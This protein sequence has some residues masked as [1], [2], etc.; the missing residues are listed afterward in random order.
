MQ[1]IDAAVVFLLETMK[2]EHSD[3]NIVSQ[4][5]R[6]IENIQADDPTGPVNEA[7]AGIRELT[8][9]GAAEAQPVEAT[10]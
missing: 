5:I 3:P 10:S 7:V 4:A 1:N 2:R 8:G 9:G 6:H